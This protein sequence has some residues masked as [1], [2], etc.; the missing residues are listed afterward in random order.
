M[1]R[2]LGSAADQT[3]QRIIDAARDLFVERGYAGTSVRDISERLGMTKGSLYYHF[4]SKDELLHALVAPLV[5][6]VDAV[7]AEAHATRGCDEGLIR[8]LV[9]LFD[10]HSS[11]LRQLIADPSASRE[12]RR[13]HALRVRIPALALALAGQDGPGAMLRGRCALGVIHAGVMAGQRDPDAPAA[14]TGPGGGGA[15]RLTEADKRY[16]I[17]ATLAVLAVP[18]G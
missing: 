15:V 6:D 11:V 16:I 17:G 14:D 8:R 3:R 10:E 7:I 12:L 5:E 4:A 13:S 18:A 1:A 9:D 2:T